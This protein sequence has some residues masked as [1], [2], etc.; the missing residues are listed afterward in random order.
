M[1]RLD[2]TVDFNLVLP[3]LKRGFHEFL[4]DQYCIP[5]EESQKVVV[6]I[7]MRPGGSLDVRFKSPGEDEWVSKWLSLTDTSS[8]P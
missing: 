4:V 3:Y 8:A 1:A 7:R 2:T 6:Q 5:P